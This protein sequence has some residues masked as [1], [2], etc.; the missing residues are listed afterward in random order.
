M[1]RATFLVLVVLAVHACLS[2]VMADKPP[3]QPG[4]LP[5][6]DQDLDGDSNIKAHEQGTV[7]VEGTVTVNDLASVLAKLDAE[8]TR[9][10]PVLS[11]QGLVAA[12]DPTAAPEASV[13]APTQSPP[14]STR[15][16]VT[17][18]AD[19]GGNLRVIVRQAARTIFLGSVQIPGNGRHEY[20]PADVSGAE[21]VVLWLVSEPRWIDG[22]A[23]WQVAPG[24]A[25]G[26]RTE[27]RTCVVGPTR[28]GTPLGPYLVCRVHNRNATRAATVAAY[29]YVTY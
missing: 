14:K 15:M 10:Q 18:P 17:G 19:E 24:G 25:A 9:S 8:R 27:A 11:L 26:T 23:H 7:N 12:A 1:V 28:L 3:P 29:A 5:V 2:P 13:A 20:P 21:T 22:Y 4:P 16:E 6:A